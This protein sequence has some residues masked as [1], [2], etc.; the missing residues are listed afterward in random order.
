M[1][2]GGIGIPLFF[3]GILSGMLNDIWLLL[4]V[5]CFAFIMPMFLIMMEM[6]NR[7]NYPIRVTVSYE[8]G[9]ERGQKNTFS[10]EDRIGY[11]ETK[12]ANGKNTGAK[13]W[14]LMDIGRCVQNFSYD[15]VGD[16]T[17]W[18]GLKIG[19]H[20]NI[21]AIMGEK[22]EEFFPQKYDASSKTYKPVFDGDRGTRLLKIFS[23]IQA[24]NHYTDWIK[25]NL[26]QLAITGIALAI[27]V[28]LFLCFMQL[29]DVSKTLRDTMGANNA[30]LA[31]SA[32]FQNATNFNA[33]QTTVNPPKSNTIAGVPFAFG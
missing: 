21:I 23:D 32:Y 20:A 11:R 1:F 3:V 17:M 13:E 14:R 22:G 6:N 24:R 9:G 16:K 28:M 18:F 26:I 30:C 4:G 27:T 8:L 12:D 7:R 25:Q 33:S 5:G 10:T 2:F 31:A 19:R 15:Y 29:S